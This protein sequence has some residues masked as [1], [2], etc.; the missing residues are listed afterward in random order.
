MN[1][2]LNR[3][4]EE[5]QKILN[6]PISLGDSQ[7]TLTSVFKLLVIVVLVPVAE[8]FLRR[9]VPARTH[10]GPDLQNAL[11]RFA[12]YCFI[13]V[14]MFFAFKVVH[15]DLSAFAVMIGALGVGI[16]FGLQN[17]VSNFISGLV[18]LAERPIAI[19]HR[20]DG[21]RC[22]WTGHPDQPAQHDGRDE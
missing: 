3:W 10:L 15:L 2:A 16:G 5:F 1:E 12:G 6:Y 19:G 18:I 21:R 13:A 8:R 14:G 20:I 22:G 11:S 4:W 17:I 7:L 9:R